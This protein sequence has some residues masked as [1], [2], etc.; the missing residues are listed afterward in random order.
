MQ[1]VTPKIDS[2]MG[3]E[4]VLLQC[5]GKCRGTLMFSMG[6]QCGQTMLINLVKKHPKKCIRKILLEWNKDIGKHLIPSIECGLE[7]IAPKE[8]KD[9]SK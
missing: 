3:E 2:V 8:I 9:V 6:Q 4:R 7:V 5:H 1:A